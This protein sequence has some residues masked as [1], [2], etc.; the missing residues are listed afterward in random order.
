MEKIAVVQDWSK[1]WFACLEYAYVVYCEKCIISPILSLEK[2][3]WIS[4]ETLLIHNISDYQANMY[5]VSLS[6]VS[7]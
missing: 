2:C 5:S 6:Y 1:Q 7:E 3:G 4:F